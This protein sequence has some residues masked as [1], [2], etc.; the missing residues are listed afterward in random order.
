[1][2]Q[3]E[4][5]ANGLSVVAAEISA[6]VVDLA[7]A[8]NTLVAESADDIER[9]WRKNAT[10]SAGEHGK[11]Y[12]KSIKAEVLDDGLTADIEPDPGMPQGEMSFE[13]GSTNQPPH[14][15]GQR[16]LDENAPRFARRVAALR[17]LE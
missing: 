6:A 14:L 15:D 8:G 2:P 7:E 17:F 16:A 11:H 1:M 13:N 4:F 9:D 5:E 3:L 10:E 12:V